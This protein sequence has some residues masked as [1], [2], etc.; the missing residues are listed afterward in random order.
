[1]SEPAYRKKIDKYVNEVTLR[2]M[3]ELSELIPETAPDKAYIKAHER[4]EKIIRSEIWIPVEGEAIVADGCS[5][6]KIRVKMTA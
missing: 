5:T 6:K 1:M 4:I 2:I 3:N